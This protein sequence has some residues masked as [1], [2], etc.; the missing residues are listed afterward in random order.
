MAK[1]RK[2]APRPSAPPKRAEKASADTGIKAPPFFHNVLL[3][4]GLIFAFAFLLYANTLNHGFVLDDSIVISSNMFTEKGVEGIPGILSKDTFFGFFKVEGK[5]TLV[6]GGRYRPLTLVFFALIYEVFGNNNFVFH[7]FTVLLFA[8]TC[9]V[10]YRSL[11]LLFEPRMGV[12]RSHLLAWLAAVLFAA[13]PIH[14][15]VVAN[16]KGC[17]E[18]ATLL[19]SLGAL[20]FTL[21]AYDTQH[22]KWYIAAG[23]SFFLACLSKENAATFLLII[24][25]ALWFFR[26]NAGTETKSSIFRVVLPVLV[27]FLVFFVLRGSILHWRF[28][29][30]PM[31]LMNNPFLKIEGNQWV[32]FA[33]AEKLATVFYTLGKYIWLLFVPLTLTHD[34]Y[35]N[36][37]GL[38]TFGDPVVLVSIVLYVGMAWY[39]LNG[40]HRRD[41]VRFGILYYL[42]TLSIVS[43]LV[44]PV[45]TAMGDRFLFM[46]SVGFCVVIASWL[47]RLSKGPK[48]MPTLG[49]LG[50]ILLFFSF[51]TIS[52]NSAWESNEKLF[53]TDV[54]TSTNSAK[55]QNACGGVL[56]EKAIAT[57]DTSAQKAYCRRATGYLN[58]AIAIHPNY[59]DAYI[60]RGGCHY[61]LGE[62][63][64][65]VSDYRQAMRIA[66]ND[67]KPRTGLAIALRDGGKFYGEKRGDLVTAYQ[68]LSESWKVNPKDPETARLLGVLYGVQG[69]HADAI[70]WFSKAV[71]LAPDNARFVLDLS[72]AYYASGDQARG[73]EY[74]LKALKIN[75]NILKEMGQGR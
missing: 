24:P 31:E 60:A 5:E 16:I 29:G 62:F 6:S 39:A 72:T 48:L 61:L 66:E 59:K 47:L 20:F 53:F 14:T 33:P 23:V 35:P 49:L 1:Q 41:P 2:P 45:G 69:K 71:E 11:I 30:E 34:Y 63:D 67:P 25:L 73:E 40:L 13:H 4:S 15:E 9:V 51:K 22:S 75:P 38:K 64:A 56:F 8:F 74:R 18:I 7:L 58:K 12:D 36:Q 10:L 44:F 65:A 19:G 52:R 17:D 68:M 55:I 43:N 37:I 32:K 54:E 46:P 28:G 50:A 3:Q 27:A 57:T 70:G 42:I 26:E 21:K